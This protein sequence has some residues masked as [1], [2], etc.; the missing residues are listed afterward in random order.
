MREGALGKVVFSLGFDNFG[1]E[2]VVVEVSG[3]EGV[4]KDDTAW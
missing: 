2:K 3:G 1:C 4:F